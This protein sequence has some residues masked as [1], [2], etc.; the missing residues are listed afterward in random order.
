MPETILIVD[1][2]TEMADTCAR[3]LRAGGFNCLVA[4]DSAKAFALMDSERPALVVSDIT[5]PD[6]DGFEMARHASKKS[7]KIPVVLMTAYHTPE[8]ARNV[9]Q[10]G[11]A[12]YLRKPFPNAE[13]IAIVKMLLRQHV[14]GKSEI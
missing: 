9:Q 10:A 11:A 2:E 13:L 1:D 7:P 8:I 14:N 6:S 4:Y 3:V 12:G 5:M